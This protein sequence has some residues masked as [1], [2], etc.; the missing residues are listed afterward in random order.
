MNLILDESQYPE[1]RFIFHI[2]GIEYGWFAKF[3][4]VHEFGFMIEPQL[5]LDA[6]SKDG[7]K[8]HFSHVGRE[9][10]LVRWDDNYGIPPVCHFSLV[11]IGDVIDAV[12]IEDPKDE[13]WK[14]LGQS[15]GRLS[16]YIKPASPSTP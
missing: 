10:K 5:V 11:P 7:K 2:N 12:I 16:V 15:D 4:L 13:G 9:Y 14:Y 3:R 1:I 6:V 8:L